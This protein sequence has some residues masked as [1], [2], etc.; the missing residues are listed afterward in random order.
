MKIKVELTFP[1]ELRDEPI[2]Y[3]I[4]HNF[5]VVPTIIEASFS[6]ETGWAI[7]LLEGEKE[8]MDRVFNYLREKNI[9]IDQREKG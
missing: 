2:I 8:E 6:T 7:L 4:G 5:K 3:Y 1:A 9:I